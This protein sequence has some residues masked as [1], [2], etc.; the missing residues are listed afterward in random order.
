MTGAIIKAQPSHFEGDETA[1]TFRKLALKYAEIGNAEGIKIRPFV[2]PDMPLFQKAG[3]LERQQAVD[4]LQTIVSIH[5]ET[6]A[7]G[8]RVIDSKR[9]IWRALGKLSLVPGA[10]VFENFT[11]DDIVLIYSD[12]QT[13]LFWNLQFFK[14][15]SLTVEHLFFS[16][17]HMVTK[18]APE[19]HEKL[20]QM[21]IDIISGKIKGTF[22]PPVPGHEVQEVDTAECLRTWMELPFGSVLTRNGALGGIMIVQR[23]KII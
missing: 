3:P 16:P 23:M 7:A 9:L 22:R 18:R 4:F 17:W 14:F 15:I 8:E 5:E 10:D 20:Y 6:L 13:I 1:D 12:N 19:I 21:A 11:D 2:S